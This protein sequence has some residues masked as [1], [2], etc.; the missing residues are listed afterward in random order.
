MM[1]PDVSDYKQMT[2]L[3]LTAERSFP[4]AN[5]QDG[6]ER[7]LPRSLQRMKTGFIL[8]GNQALDRE[9]LHGREPR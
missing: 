4:A 1:F 8:G 3:R 6:Y 7:D 2:A 5:T 9:A